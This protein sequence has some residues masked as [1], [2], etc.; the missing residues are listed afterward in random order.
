M[1]NGSGDRE[2]LTNT[3]EGLL[4]D[5]KN[6]LGKLNRSSDKDVQFPVECDSG[7]GTDL[8]RWKDGLLEIQWTWVDL[9]G[10]FRSNFLP[11]R[12]GNRR[13]RKGARVAHEVFVIGGSR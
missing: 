10:F 9:Y 8:P 6:T 7:F 3:L 4:E 13:Q 12:R 2:E 1:K 5:S 11:L